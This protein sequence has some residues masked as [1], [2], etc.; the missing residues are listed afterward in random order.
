MRN[1]NLIKRLRAETS[2]IWI[3][4]DA[5]D[6]LE[7]MQKTICTFLHDLDSCKAA[8][9]DIVKLSTGMWLQV[10]AFRKLVK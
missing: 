3:C 7:E 2:D 1:D 5:A 8:Y 4:I 6:R 10:E 9:P